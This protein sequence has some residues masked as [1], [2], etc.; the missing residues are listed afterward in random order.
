ML[1]LANAAVF[2]AL[3]LLFVHLANTALK[4][5]GHAKNLAYFSWG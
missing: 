3:A 1:A 2:L 5:L 4:T